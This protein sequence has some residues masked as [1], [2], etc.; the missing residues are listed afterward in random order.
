M[1]GILAVKRES[2]E[3]NC[4]LRTSSAA[5]LLRLGLRTHRLTLPV[6]P[7]L[8][9]NNVRRGFVEQARFRAVALLATELWLRLFLEMAFQYGWRKQELLGLRVRQVDLRTN[10]IRL[11]VGT[12]KDEY[13]EVQPKG[14]MQHSVPPQLEMD[15]AFS[16]LR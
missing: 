15:K 12:T 10:L 3:R 1:A 7:H 6:L 2:G 4:Q 11:D 14:T 9:E 5:N 13:G 8:V 16:R